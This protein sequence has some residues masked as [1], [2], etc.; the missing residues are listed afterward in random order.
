MLDFI[1]LSVVII[2]L[3]LRYVR[4]KKKKWR[5]VRGKG[6]RK[7]TEICFDLFQSSLDYKCLFRIIVLVCWLDCEIVIREIEMLSRYLVWFNDEF[8]GNF[9]DNKDHPILRPNHILIKKKKWLGQLLNFVVPKD[10]EVWIKK[11]NR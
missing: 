7:G 1:I 6:E 9:C 5:G 11:M 2:T 3:N 4:K 10:Y 8:S